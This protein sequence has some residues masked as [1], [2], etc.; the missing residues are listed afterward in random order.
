MK[1]RATKIKALQALAKGDASLLEK[2]RPEKPLFV[3]YKKV[4]NKYRLGYGAQLTQHEFTEYEKKLLQS[5]QPQ[6]V[7][8]NL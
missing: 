5:K 8:E 4:G 3:S 7:V 1:D 6:Y 2:I